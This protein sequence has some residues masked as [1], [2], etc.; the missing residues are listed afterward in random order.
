MQDASAV[1]ANLAHLLGN[2]LP[3]E[4]VRHCY[5]DLP[6][7]KCPDVPP[8]FYLRVSERALGFLLALAK[9]GGQGAEWA[10]SAAASV[11][12]LLVSPLGTDDLRS[13]TQQCSCP[14]CNLL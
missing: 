12:S 14:K 13:V 1:K 3:L 4:T 5:S 2:N 10:A 8:D 7:A 11:K 6:A 9:C